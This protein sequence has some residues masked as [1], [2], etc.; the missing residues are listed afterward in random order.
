[1]S[2]SRVIAG[3]VRSAHDSQTAEGDEEQ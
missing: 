3:V 1:V 2:D